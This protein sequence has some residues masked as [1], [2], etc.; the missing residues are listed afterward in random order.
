MKKLLT[1]T[2]AVLATL[3]LSA[4]TTY[5][6]IPG[7]GTLNTTDFQAG[8][9]I[10]TNG[11]QEFESVACTNY[12]VF[13]STSSAPSYAANKTIVYNCK[14]TETAIKIYAYNKNSSDKNLYITTFDEAASAFVNETIKVAKNGGKEVITKS[15]SN[16]TNKTIY[17]CVSSTDVQIFKYD[18]TE[19]G[20]P[21][22]QAGEIGYSF[23]FN[24]SRACLASS[25]TTEYNIE[26]M[27]IV[28]VSSNHTANNSTELQIKS[29]V[30]DGVITA[31]AYVEFTAAANCQLHVKDNNGKGY[32][33]SQTLAA[34][35]AEDLII[36][37]DTA[38]DVSAGKWYIISSDKGAIKFNLI[39]FLAPDLNPKF[40]VD[41]ASVDLDVAITNPNPSAKVKFTGKNLTD[42]TY[43]LT[44]TDVAGLSASPMQLTVT[45]GL[46]NQEV[47]ISYTSNVDVT[48][49]VATLSATINEIEKSVTINY[50]AV[51]SGEKNYV[52]ASVNIE[53]SIVELG[54]TFATTNSLTAAGWE[55]AEIN[56][57]DSLNNS[58]GA[59]RNE[60]YLGVKFNASTDAFV[61]GWIKEGDVLRAKFGNIPGAVLVSL[62]GGEPTELTAATYE[63][64]AAADTYVKF[65]PKTTGSKLVLK[66]L[67]L[68]ETLAKVMNAV[69]YAT[70]ENG[71][72]SGWKI[73]YPGEKVTLT[74]TPAEGYQIASVTLDGDVL[75]ADGD[76]YSFDMPAKDVAVAATFSVATAIDNTDAAVK[77]TKV[78]RD[79]QVLILRDGKFFNTLGVEVK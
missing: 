37:K 57:N 65:S 8:L 61:A 52:T 24:K 68:N 49:A 4:Q 22:K 26:G 67:M 39:E 45:D 28:G 44:L 38:V 63:L 41:N 34:G 36:S 43:N 60:S 25:T 17:L 72:V 40:N 27:K 23:N 29:T 6:Y 18:V 33:V 2:A 7:D 20:T 79:G 64:T 15:Y 77:A 5:S 66:Q 50:S 74:V 54:K 19:S 12:A 1:L 56:G 14:T 11:N 35:E 21:L 32:W 53:G 16:T 51:T 70:A 30:T 9:T 48:A 46:L 55:F 58:K 13:G 42:G 31:L 76:V 75:V 69:E 3:V 71:E 47:T 62:N 73:A 78:L 10:N 59:L